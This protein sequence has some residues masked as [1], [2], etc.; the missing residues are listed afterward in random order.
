[1]RHPILQH[2]LLRWN[3][4][5]ECFKFRGVKINFLPEDIALILA[6][7]TNGDP[8]NYT[9]KN[10]VKSSIKSKYFNPIGEISREILELMILELVLEKEKKVLEADVVRL[11]IMYIFTTILFPMG[12]GSVPAQFFHYVDNLD[13]LWDYSWG[14]TVYNVLMSVIPRCAAWC[15]MME[16][17]N[18]LAS[19]DVNDTSHF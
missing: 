9:R 13:K 1:L 10:Q 5:E 15:R 2:I 3:Q 14:K 16:V 19:I 7:P 4:N 12:S 8:D 11:L 6:L 18:N 17:E